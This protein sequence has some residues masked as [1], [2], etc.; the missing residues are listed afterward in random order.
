VRAA[1]LDGYRVIG[2]RDLHVCVAEKVSPQYTTDGNWSR[3]NFACRRN[4]DTR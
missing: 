3:D 4:A 1:Q 2:S